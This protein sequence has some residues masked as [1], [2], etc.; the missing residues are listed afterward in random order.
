MCENEK[1][2]GFGSKFGRNQ[3]I[4]FHDPRIVASMMCTSET[5]AILSHMT[6]PSDEINNANPH[7]QCWCVQRIGLLLQA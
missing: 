5:Q 4:D 2:N 6:T 7:V 3:H 1:P